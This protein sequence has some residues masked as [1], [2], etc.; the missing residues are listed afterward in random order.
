VG[1]PQS[2]QLLEKDDQPIHA[3]PPD[4][5]LALAISL[6]DPVTKNAES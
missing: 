2:K 6:P 4:K 1:G 5:W 3:I